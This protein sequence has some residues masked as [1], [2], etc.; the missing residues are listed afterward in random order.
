MKNVK[1]EKGITLI[2]LII[3]II[4]LLILAVVTIGSMQNSNIITYAQNASSSYN[5]GKEDEIGILSKY[6]D[7]LAEQEGWKLQSDLVTIKNGKTG[8]IKRIGDIFENSYVLD[9]T[10]GVKSSYEGTWTVIGAENGKLKLVSTTDVATGVKLGTE[11]QKLPEKLEEIFN[12]EGEDNFDLEK[13]LW[14]YQHA[15]ENLD[16]YAK[17]ETGIESARSINIEDLEKK[18]ILN[19]TEDKKEE[20]WNTYGPTVKYL[21]DTEEQKVVSQ[22][23]NEE[24]GNFEALS[25]GAYAEA[26]FINQKG[27]IIKIDSNNSKNEVILVSNDYKDYEF[28]N[29]Q[30]N[31]FGNSLA[32]ESYWLAS[33]FVGCRGSNAGF[34]IPSVNNGSKIGASAIFIS[35]GDVFRSAAKGVRA[36]VYI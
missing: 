12:K 10:G 34:T 2:A 20:L 15:I 33:N 9:A 29:E 6:E 7:I 8:E 27:E 36:I 18:E 35:N 25:S 32:N 14:S 13:A 26:I 23:K 4:I 24:N 3:T 31:K 28:T 11:D 1:S 22:K 16:S 21:Y 17:T 30:K 5:K 19:I